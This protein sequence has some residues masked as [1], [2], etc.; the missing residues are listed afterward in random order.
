MTRPPPRPGRAER[1]AAALRQN[2]L[3]RK[4]QAR[5]REAAAA[6]ADQEKSTD[7]PLA[8]PAVPINKEA[9]FP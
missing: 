9:E 6:H 8:G 1:E 7:Q 2:L 4:D 3:K 5:R